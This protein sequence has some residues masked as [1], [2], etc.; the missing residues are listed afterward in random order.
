MEVVI[1]T[2]SLSCFWCERQEFYGENIISSS[3]LQAHDR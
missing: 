2:G 3:L 1:K